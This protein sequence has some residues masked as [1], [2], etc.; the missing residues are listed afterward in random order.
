MQNETQKLLKRNKTLRRMPSAN[1]EKDR[2]MAA[3]YSRFSVPFRHAQSMT[4]AERCIEMRN[5]CRLVRLTSLCE[6]TNQDGAMAT[7]GSGLAD[8]LVQLAAT[9]Q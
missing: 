2:T 1:A 8:D 9:L 5:R 7:R 3:S 6:G 4:R